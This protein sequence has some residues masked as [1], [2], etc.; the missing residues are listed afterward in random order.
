M[1][2]RYHATRLDGELRAAGVPLH[3]CNSNGAIHFKDEATAAHR[4]R[5]AEILAAHDFDACCVAEN[6]AKARAAKIDAEMRRIAE[7][8]LIARGE[9]AP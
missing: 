2:A 4:A 9:L 3:G 6:T 8:R 5:A 1:N 7:E